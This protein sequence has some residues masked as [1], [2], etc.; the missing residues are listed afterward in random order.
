M[1]KILPLILIIIVLSCSRNDCENLPTTFDTY[2]EAKS[3][4]ENANF[5]YEEE[6]NTN[7]SSW[8]KS[9]KYYSCDNRTGF[10]IL[11]TENKNYIY[12]NVPFNIWKGFENATSYGRFYNEFI[13]YKFPLNIRT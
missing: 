10:L 1:Q 3:Q 11:E 5:N 8:I 2:D 9:A 7:R 4:I 6:V 12:Q 13:K